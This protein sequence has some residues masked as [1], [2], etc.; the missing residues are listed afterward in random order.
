MV[1]HLKDDKTIAIA[2]CVCRS[3]RA[4]AKDA[5]SELSVEMSFVEMC[6]EAF[7]Y[8]LAVAK[9]KPPHNHAFE[10]FGAC[11]AGNLDLVRRLTEQNST[12]SCLT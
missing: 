3:W 7:P 12:R 5:L 1:T 10:I 8:E 11:I 6:K 9:I 4:V 2:G